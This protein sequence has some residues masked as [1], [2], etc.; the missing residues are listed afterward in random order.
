[1][2]V[3]A[4]G[5]RGQRRPAGWRG[6]WEAHGG[7]RGTRLA[8]REPR[9]ERG[10]TWKIPQRLRARR[11]GGELRLI[12]RRRVSARAGAAA[13]AAVPLWRRLTGRRRGRGRGEGSVSNGSDGWRR[14]VI[15][16]HHPV[17][18]TAVLVGAA[19]PRPGSV[20]RPQPKSARPRATA[21]LATAVRRGHRQSSAAPACQGEPLGLRRCFLSFLRQQHSSK[22]VARS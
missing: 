10:Y 5:C 7:C 4:G 12:P 9:F 15:P 20:R 17:P 2:A 21:E 16:H 8:W 14:G 18:L 19:R 3:A 22:Q 11:G 13:A 6:T 1:M